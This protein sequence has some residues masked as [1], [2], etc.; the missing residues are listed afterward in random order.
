MQDALALAFK[1]V[2]LAMAAMTIAFIA[3][4]EGDRGI[5]AIFLAIGLFSIAVGSVMDHRM[6]LG[7]N[8]RGP[9]PT[10]GRYGNE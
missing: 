9:A 10:N 8:T 2:A 7:R 5:S 6:A 4:G 1:G 3:L